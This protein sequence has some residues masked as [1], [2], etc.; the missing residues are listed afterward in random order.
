[1]V[2][3]RGIKSRFIIGEKVLCYEPDVTKAKVLYDSKVHTFL[4]RN[5]VLDIPLSLD[6]YCAIHFIHFLLC[7]YMPI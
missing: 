4:Y 2:S 1:M 3:T 7:M 6:L 5:K